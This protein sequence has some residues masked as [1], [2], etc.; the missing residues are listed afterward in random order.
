M[1]DLTPQLE[2]LKILN[3]HVNVVPFEL[4]WAQKRYM[5]VVNEQLASTGRVRIIVLKARQIGVSTVT[6]ANAFVMSF[7]IPNYKVMVICHEKEASQNLLAMTSR[8][9]DNHPYKT[10]GLY[11]TKYAGRNHI[12]WEETESSIYVATAGNEETGRSATCH[13]LHASELG[14]WPNPSTTY[15]SIRQTIPDVSTGT[16]IVL[17]STANGIGNFFH[18]TWV[19]SCLG[20]NEYQP[21][22]FPWWEHPEYCA[23]A[24]GIP[25][26]KIEHLDEDEKA[27]VDLMRNPPSE[28]WNLYEPSP[29]LSMEEIYDRLTWRKYAIKNLVENR[30]G[31]TG[32]ATAEDFKQE[33]PATPEEAFK[34]S[35]TNVFNYENLT[36]CFKRVQG[37]RGRLLRNGNRV[38]FES[39]RDGPFTVYRRPA[40]DTEFGIYVV[41]GDPTHTTRGDYAS[42]QVINRRTLEQVAVLRTR[43]DPATFAQDLYKIGLYYNTALTTSEI[44]GPGYSTIG[45][46]L[47]MNYPFIPNRARADSTPGKVSTEQYGW[48]T[49]TQSK[50]LAIGWLIKVVNDGSLI[51]HDPQTYQ[52]MTNYVTLDN[53]GYGNANGEPNDDTVM[54]LAIAVITHMMEPPVAA[55]GTMGEVEPGSDSMPQTMPWERWGQGEQDDSDN[56]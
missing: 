53:G 11:H 56:E 21:L 19:N 37:Y 18:S 32:Q 40:E 34:S 5:R 4:N 27:L 47:G 43:T 17:E 13:F 49:T 24:I 36:R 8:Y 16:F 38:T 51:L 28:R 6:E 46:L 2:K 7:L 15:L 55:Y 41:A 22:F 54:S 29:P 50:H 9:W 14:F 52:E 20:E 45:A 39:D 12:A 23:S 25:G 31:E 30:A 3:K 35:G 10:S 26:T 48:S 44:E 1:I 33:Y 42:A